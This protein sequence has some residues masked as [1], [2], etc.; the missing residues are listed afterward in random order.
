MPSDRVFSGE[1]VTL[2]CDLEEGVDWTY[3]WYKDDSV[4]PI[5]TERVYKFTSDESDAGKYTCRG[6]KKRDSRRSEISDAVT[7]TVSGSSN[8]LKC[9]LLTSVFKYKCLFFQS[10]YSD[11]RFHWSKYSSM[12]FEAGLHVCL[13]FPSNGRWEECLRKQLH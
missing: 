2:R 12:F 3:G 5:S 6:E 11:W 4:V 7:L 13:F 9:L 1:T 10:H 8:L